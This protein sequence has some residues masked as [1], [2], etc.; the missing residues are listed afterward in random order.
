MPQAFEKP[1]GYMPRAVDAQIER[2]LSV[3]AQLRLRGQNG[4]AKR[5]RRLSTVLP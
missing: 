1:E 4:A 2:Y 5:G 3:L